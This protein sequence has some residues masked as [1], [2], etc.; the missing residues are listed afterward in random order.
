MGNSLWREKQ[1]INYSVRAPHD[2]SSNLCIQ[3]FNLTDSPKEIAE[4][5]T[6]YG[7]VIF[8]NILNAKEIELTIDALWSQYPSASRDDPTT[9]D[10]IFHPNGI[11][12][13]N[14]LI[15]HKQ[16]WENRQHPNV[17]QAFKLLYEIN[18]KQSKQTGRI[19]PLNEPLIA[20]LSR[21]SIML[22]TTGDYGKETWKIQRIPHFDMNPYLWTQPTNIIPIDFHIEYEDDL[23]P[24]LVIEGNNYSSSH[25]YPMLRAVLQLSE[26]TEETG[27]L[28]LLPGFHRYLTTWC[29]EHSLFPSNTTTPTPSQQQ[30]EVNG[31]SYGLSHDNP[32]IQQFQKMITLPGSLIVFSA[33]LPHTMFPNESNQ[34]RYAQYLKMTPL[35]GLELSEEEFRK[36]KALIQRHLPIDL[37]VTNIGEEVFFGH[38]IV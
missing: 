30:Y 11:I 7:F 8:R 17:Y 36:R 28:E 25:G 31:Y 6:E 14:P 27:G 18:S 21:G 1:Q 3:S 24:F 2:E 20:N 12:G 4:F 33:E 19:C 22:P 10:T 16:F 35:S 38:T 15:N 29:K 23:L 9:W 26:S 34:F 32:L 13:N 5:Y 37:E